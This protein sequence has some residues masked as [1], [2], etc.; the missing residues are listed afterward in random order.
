MDGGTTKELLRKEKIKEFVEK[1]D[2]TDPIIQGK[3]EIEKWIAY[4][5][6]LMPLR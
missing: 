3:C 5:D 4:F 1:I 2:E 6:G